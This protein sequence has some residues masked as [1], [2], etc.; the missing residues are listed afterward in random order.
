MNNVILMGR[1]TTQPELR[2]LS[3]GNS[4]CSFTLAVDKD[5]NSQKRK[6]F[7][8]QNKPTADFI[9]CQ[10]WGKTGEAI[11]RYVKKG[12]RLLVQGRIQTG[13]YDDK[14]GKRIY[15]TDVIVY[16]SEIID[17]STND[18]NSTFG[19]SKIVEDGL[20]DFADDFE[21]DFDPT[22]DDGRIPF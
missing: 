11:A 14:D 17:W 8:S 12:K 21:T 1:P 20:R 18:D 9:N 7:E 19:K 3:N 13:F 15:T 16:N 4:V 2:H 5:L 6:E 22:I 10:A